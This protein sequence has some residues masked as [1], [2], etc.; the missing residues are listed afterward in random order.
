MSITETDVGAFL[1]V[2]LS[3]TQEIMII[4]VEISEE[5]MARMLTGK[6]VE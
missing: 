2:N 1:N 3:K 6:R 5:T 4:K